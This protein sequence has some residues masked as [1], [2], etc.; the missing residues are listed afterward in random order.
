M[1][2][3][4]ILPWKRDGKKLPI[5]RDAEIVD[6]TEYPQAYPLL[7]LQNEMN[8]LFEDFWRDPFSMRPFERLT[9][10]GTTGWGSFNPNVDISETDKEIK[11][12]AELPGLDEKDIEISI[13]E[14]VLTIKGEK[15]Q[16]SERKDRNYYYAERSYGTF[17]RQFALPNAVDENKIEATFKKGV[18]TVT[19]PKRP[20]VVEQRKRIAIKSA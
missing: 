18:L 11:L 15:H 17:T 10:M 12:E 6:N 1:S 9:R 4:S 13:S 5:Q 19:M 7:S 3:K 16:E 8:R 14:D 20:E 2:L